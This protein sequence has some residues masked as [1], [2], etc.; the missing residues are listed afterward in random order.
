MVL[1]L[2]PGDGEDRTDDAGLEILVL[3]RETVYRGGHDPD[4]LAVE[5]VPDELL[6]REDV[7]VGLGHVPSQ[8]VPGVPRQ[9][10]GS[11]DTDVAAPDHLQIPGVYMRDQ[12]G[13]LWVMDVDDV[14]GLHQPE[15]LVRCLGERVLVGL[16]LFGPEL[17]AIP[18]GLVQMVVEPLRDA[19]EARV[20]GDRHPANVG[21]TAA[22]I[23]EQRLQQLGDPAA[24][25]GRVDVPDDPP[26]EHLAGGLDRLLNLL[27][28]VAEQWPEALRRHC[29]DVDLLECGH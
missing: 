20:A 24:L 6:A 21:A 15:E 22:R 3:R 17:S 12:T 2:D 8:K 18:G 27:V 23:G 28:A 1:L 29:R 11:V 10:P 14:A 16:V 7:G 4:P 5:L 25:G 26:G 13:R 19:E 9:R